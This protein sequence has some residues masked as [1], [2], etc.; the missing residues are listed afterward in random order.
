MSR[1]YNSRKGI[2][3][4]KS[5]DKECFGEY[6]KGKQNHKRDILK[7]YGILFNYKRKKKSRYG[8]WTTRMTKKGNCYEAEFYFEEYHKSDVYDDDIIRAKQS[9]RN[10]SWLDGKKNIKGYVPSKYWIF[11]IKTKKSIREYYPCN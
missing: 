11:D 5:W 8:Y 9:Y 4:Y 7:F 3:P 1:S 2:Y 6:M 10:W